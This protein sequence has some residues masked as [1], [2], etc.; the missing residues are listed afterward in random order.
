MSH[1]KVREL[2]GRKFD[3]VQQGLDEGQ[4]AEFIDELIQQRDTLLEQINSLLSYIRFSKSMVGKQDEPIGSSGQQVE[5]RA[6]GTV[7]EMDQ[8]IQPAVETI[9]IEQ[10]T[11]VLPEATKAAEA[12]KKEEPA[13]YQGEL[14]LAILPPVDEAGLLQFGRRLRNSFQLKIL[15]TDGSPSKGSLIAVLLSEPQP[16]LQ[17]LKQIPEVK[18]AVEELDTS[19]QVKGTLPSLFKNKQGERI[20]VTLHAQAN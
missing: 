11:P 8:D 19:A 16:L 15:S 4:V 6:T 10:A 12:G 9:E 13:L 3:V 2:R 14:E 20:W 1:G 17:G 7:T 18:E 5:N